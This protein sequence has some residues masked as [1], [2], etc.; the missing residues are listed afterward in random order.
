[1][2]GRFRKRFSAKLRPVAAVLFRL[3][4]QPSEVRAL[5]FGARER[6]E[7]VTVRRQPHRQLRRRLVYKPSARIT[8]I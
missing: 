4:A 6:S 3:S 2:G 5:G 1:M 7:R 8:A